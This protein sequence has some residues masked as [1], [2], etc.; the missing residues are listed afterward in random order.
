LFLGQQNSVFA[1]SIIIGRRKATSTMKFKAGLANSVAFFRA[2]DGESPVGSWSIGDGAILNASSSASIG[3]NDFSGG[4]VDALV[5]TL[6]VGRSQQTSGNN[7]IGV[8][9][10]SDGTFNVN[11]LQIGF[12]TQAGVSAGIG[13]VTLNGAGAVLEVNSSVLL[14]GCGG[15]VGTNVTHGVL[16][17]FG[18]TAGVSEIAVGAGGGTNVVAVSGGT[19]AITNTAGTATLPIDTVALTNA[20]LQLY[21]GAGVTNIVATH[22]VT[23]GASNVVNIGEITGIF[24]PGQF[25]LIQYSGAIGGAGF[26]FKLGAFPAD[27]MAGGYLSNNVANSSVDLVITNLLVLQT[28]FFTSSTTD[29][30]NVIFQGVNGPPNGMF[31]LRASA[32][33]AAPVETWPIIATNIFD[34]DG[35][36]SITAPIEPGTNQLFYLLQLQ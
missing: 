31:W 5:N 15:V 19:L 12:Q 1:D 2:S 23:G 35:E 7:G 14:G 11:T 18:G 24:G 27:V 34:E 13:T 10:F 25:P 30:T 33:V 22:L 6:T 21:V 20:S 36:F 28:P 9:T 26:N 32:N 17:I 29:G 16:N 4:T 8:L 3:T